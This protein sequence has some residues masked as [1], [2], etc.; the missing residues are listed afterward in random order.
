MPFLSSLTGNHA[1][2][3]RK[4]ERKEKRKKEGRKKGRK[5]E[6]K[7]ERKEKKGKLEKNH[8]PYFPLY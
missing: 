4:K 7:G 3:R 5:E 6:R 1:K 8:Q 2:I